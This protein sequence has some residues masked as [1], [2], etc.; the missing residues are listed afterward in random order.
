M[1][2]TTIIGPNIRPTRCVPCR[3]IANTPTRMT[4]VTSTTYGSK[5][6]VA[7]FSPST[8]PSTV[9]AGVIIPSP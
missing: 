7:T 4:T 9:M 2:Q 6:G 1:N 3:W 8:A 5:N